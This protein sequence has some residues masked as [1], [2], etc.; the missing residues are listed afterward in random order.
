MTNESVKINTHYESNSIEHSIYKFNK[1]FNESAERNTK[2]F[3]E[4]A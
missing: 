2:N 1:K 3:E 4:I